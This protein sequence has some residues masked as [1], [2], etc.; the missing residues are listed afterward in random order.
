[1][2]TKKRK[3]ELAI[4]KLNNNLTRC[5]NYKDCMDPTCDHYEEHPYEEPDCEEE[6]CNYGKTRCI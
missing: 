2:I 3:F 5:N 4:I 6:A 1:M